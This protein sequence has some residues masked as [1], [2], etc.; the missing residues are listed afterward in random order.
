MDKHCK[1]LHIALSHGGGVEVYTRMLIEHTHKIFDTV[2]VCSSEYNKALLPESCKIYELDIPRDVTNPTLSALIAPNLF[3]QI[4]VV[5]EEHTNDREIPNISTPLRE[6]L[7]KK[8]R[9]NVEIQKNIKS[10]FSFPFLFENDRMF[11]LP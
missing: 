3:A 10:Y 1:V 7:V 5:K 2:L 4:R 9:D 6:R 8:S 11:S